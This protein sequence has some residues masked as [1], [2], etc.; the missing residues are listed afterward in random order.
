MN[1]FEAL[2]VRVRNHPKVRQL[3]VWDSVRRF[4]TLGLKGITLN[5]GL[6][7]EPYPGVVVRVSYDSRHSIPVDYADVLEWDVPCLDR[8]KEYLK[9]ARSTCFFDIGANHGQ[10]SMVVSKW[11][12]ADASFPRGIVAFEPHPRNLKA[13]TYNLG[14]NGCFK[15]TRIVPLALAAQPGKMTLYGDS[16]TASLQPP[17][18]EDR[19]TRHQVEV[20]T[21]DGFC[22]H[23]NV[24]PDVI[25]IDVEGFE[26]DVLR[27]ATAT[28][29]A[30]QN[31]IKIICEM[32]TFMWA[33]PEYGR[34][35]I[36]VVTSCGLNVFTMTGAP[37]QVIDRFAHYVIAKSFD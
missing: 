20:Q 31:R 35:L 21:L 8:I 16:T 25:K 23:H 30:L 3:P 37:A 26:L 34:D 28:L 24:V 33:S 14:S 9:T 13:L 12:P 29:T 27:G 7:R 5:R 32:H 17:G 10:L 2:A 4:Y 1:R 6:M 22:K 15:N 36:K 19:R 18:G 11:I